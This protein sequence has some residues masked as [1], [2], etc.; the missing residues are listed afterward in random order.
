[1]LCILL[2]III[3]GRIFRRRTLPHSYLLHTKS[4][5]D[6]GTKKKRAEEIGSELYADG[7]LDAME[8]MFD[9]IEF[10]GE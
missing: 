8:D 4:G 1:L 5:S 9:S 3:N 7:G 10:R 6:F 2:L